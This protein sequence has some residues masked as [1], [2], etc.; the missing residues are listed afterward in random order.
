M[1]D[2]ILSL[3]YSQNPFGTHDEQVLVRYAQTLNHSHSHFVGEKRSQLMHLEQ[4]RHNFL[5][6][7][8]EV[9]H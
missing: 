4:V 9:E 5:V 8:A 3:D 7:H 6:G 2:L 1:L